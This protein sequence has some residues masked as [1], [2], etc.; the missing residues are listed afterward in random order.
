M[1]ANGR[2]RQGTINDKIPMTNKS[3]LL[4]SASPAIGIFTI[5]PQFEQETFRPTISVET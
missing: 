3:E 4:F 1:I 2:S 5:L